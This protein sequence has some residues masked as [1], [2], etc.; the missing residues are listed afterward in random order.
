MSRKASEDSESP[1][2]MGLGIDAAKRKSSDGVG[3]YDPGESLRQEE[4]NVGDPQIKVI[5]KEYG[6]HL[7]GHDVFGWVIAAVKH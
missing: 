1:P 3:G 4:V 5:E 6:D 2:P 7:P